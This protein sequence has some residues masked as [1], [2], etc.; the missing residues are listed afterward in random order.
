MSYAELPLEK[1][2]IGQF[3]S[4]F[5]LSSKSFSSEDKELSRYFRWSGGQGSFPLGISHHA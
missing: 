4:Q 3:Y 2:T 1:P 5:L